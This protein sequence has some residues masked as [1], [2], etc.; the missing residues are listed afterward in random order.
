MAMIP[1]VVVTTAV[2]Y[3]TA[4]VAAA[5]STTASVSAAETYSFCADVGRVPEQQGLQR[6]DCRGT[7]ILKVSV[8]VHII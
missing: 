2:A 1:A 8:L 5:K 3:T 4:F 7:A 6:P